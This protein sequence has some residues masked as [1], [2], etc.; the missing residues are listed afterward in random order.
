VVE[1]SVPKLSSEARERGPDAIV[2]R[3][4][5]FGRPYSG[6]LAVVLRVGAPYK[7]EDGMW[8]CPCELEGFESSYRDISAADPLQ[9]LCRAMARLRSRLQDF[10]AAGGVVLD[11]TTREPLDLAAAFDGLR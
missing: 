10:T 6:E 9:A 4:L 5:I 2:Q 3:E 7:E 11:A 1:P 8:A